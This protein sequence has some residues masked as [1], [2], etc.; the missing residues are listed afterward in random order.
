[1][2]EIYKQ[3]TTRDTNAFIWTLREEV[4]A[5]LLVVNGKQ[6]YVSHGYAIE[7]VSAWLEEILKALIILTRPRHGKEV[8][9]VYSPVKWRC[10]R[11]VALHGVSG[12]QRPVAELCV[13]FVDLG[14]DVGT[15][16]WQ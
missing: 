16:S 1:M 6:W 4:T 12:D 11:D 7:V 8:S 10:R 2:E 15:L 14:R 5:H 9:I 3:A 13:A